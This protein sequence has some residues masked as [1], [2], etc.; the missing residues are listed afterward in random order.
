MYD[1]KDLARFVEQATW[2]AVNDYEWQ[3]IQQKTGWTESDVTQQVEALIMTRGA[4]G[5]IIH[6]KGGPI[7]IPCAKV[8]RRRRSDR[9]WRCLSRRAHPRPVARARLADDRPHRLSHGRDQDRVARDAEP[10]SSRR[11]NSNNA[12][13]PRSRGHE[14]VRRRSGAATKA[15]AECDHHRR[16]GRRGESAPVGC[17]AGARVCRAATAAARDWQWCRS[18]RIRPRR[19]YVRNKRK[20]CQEAGHRVVRPR[21]AG[22]DQRGA[23]VGADPGAE[24][25]SARR[26]H[27]RATAAAE[28]ASIPT[29]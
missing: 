16:Q 22:D 23:A 13:P 10:H 12:S 2:V 3:L 17:R 4:D 11:Q 5:S 15:S 29:G 28:G 19:I 1:G 6:T 26:R 9:L 14:H 18:A 21:S 25:R 20:S 27:S 7:E 24:S 8:Q